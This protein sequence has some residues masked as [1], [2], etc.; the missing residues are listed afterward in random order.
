MDAVYKA[1]SKY[2]PPANEVASTAEHASQIASEFVSKVNSAQYSRVMTGHMLAQ[3]AS[4]GSQ[5][6]NDD[7]RTAEQA[8]MA[9]DSLYISYSKEGGQSP[10][11]RGAIDGLFKL[12]QNPSAY[13][14]PQ[15]R[16][17]ME[18]VRSELSAAGVR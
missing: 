9:L 12:L 1:S 13:N 14:A 11:V 8:A 16:A 5:F 17:Q 2:H 6:A 10:A 4:D 7:T 15:F 18:R 3:L